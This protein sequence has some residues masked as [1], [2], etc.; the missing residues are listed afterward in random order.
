MGLFTGK[1]RLTYC[2]HWHQGY[3]RVCDEY[4]LERAR[5]AYEKREWYHVVVGNPKKPDLFIVPM[6][7]TDGRS[8]YQV[9]C[10]KFPSRGA[11]EKKAAG[12]PRAFHEAGNRPK[13]FRIEEIPSRQ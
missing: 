13:V 8:C 4:T 12:L 9:F 10:G 7:L 2:H 1:L 5:K 11:A 3:N 6:T